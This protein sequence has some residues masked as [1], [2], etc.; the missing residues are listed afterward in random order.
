MSGLDIPTANTLIVHRADMFVLVWRQRFISSAAGWGA[1]RC[2][3]YALF[4]LPATRKITQQARTPPWK[5]LRSLDTLG[6]GFQLALRIDLDIRGAG[7]LLGEEQS[8]HI[9]EAGVRALPADRWK[10]AVEVSLK[11][12]IDERRSPTTWSPTIAIGTPV[13]I[14]EDYVA[15]LSVRL[16]LYRRLAD[17]EDEQEIDAFGTSELVAIGCSAHLPEE[18]EHLLKVVVLA[19]R[20]APARQRRED[21]D[22]AQGRGAVMLRQQLRQPGRPD[23]GFDQQAGQRQRGTRPT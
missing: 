22:R 6:A 3:P 23:Q 10:E 5:V 20:C 4:T 13:L 19:G 21:R 2:A 14:P 18:V 7:S 9:K 17:I 16:G 11:A 8:G 15:D 12:G 1:R